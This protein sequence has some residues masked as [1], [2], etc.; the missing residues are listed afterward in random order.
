[1]GESITFVGKSRLRLATTDV[2]RARVHRTGEN[3]AE[4]LNFRICLVYL[5]L[6]SGI[7][8][9]PTTSRKLLNKI[10]GT[11]LFAKLSFKFEITKLKIYN[12]KK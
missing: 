8:H 6:L 4:Y 9:G 3:L 1:M 5:L 11:F 12:H 7:F 10:L 2:R